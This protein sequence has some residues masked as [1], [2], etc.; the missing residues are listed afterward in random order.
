[1]YIYRRPQHLLL[2]LFPIFAVAIVLLLQTYPAMA[3]E[4]GLEEQAAPSDIVLSN[5]QVG[6]NQPAGTLVGTLSSVDADPGD[7][8]SY[9]VL[10]GATAYFAVD[11]DRLET[12]QALDFETEDR[13]Q[14]WI[15]STD[16]AGQSFYKSFTIVVTDANEAPTIEEGTSVAQTMSEDGSPTPFVLTLHGS[17]VDAGDSLSWSVISPAAHGTATAGG[18]GFSKVIGYAPNRNYHGSDSFEVQVTDSGGLTDTIRVHVTIE[19]VNDAP[20]ARGDSVTT[21]EERSLTISPLQND[22]DIDGDTISLVA[23]GEP[24]HGQVSQ[25]GNQITYTPEADFVGRDQINYGISDGTLTAFAT[26]NVYV[27]NVNDAPVIV[28]GTSASVTMSEDGAP[29][30]FALALSATDIDSSTVQWAI[31]SPPAHGTARATSTGPLT[32]AIDYT[33]ELHYHGTDTFR[34]QVSDGQAADVIWVDV[35]VEPVN[36]AP[37]GVD[38]TAETAEETAVIIDVLA[39]DSDVVEGS[40]LIV[41]DAGLPAHG[42]ATVNG[43]NEIVYTPQADFYGTDSFVY[44]LSDGEATSTA[45]VLVTVRNS[46]DAPVIGIVEEVQWELVGPPGFSPPVVKSFFYHLIW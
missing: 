27:T 6:E 5:D 44:T 41:Q 36:D 34:V 31:L 24:A 13:H 29:T 9:T 23:V 16:A 12:T 21:A 15:R 18:S 20:Q 33:P 19:P 14:L 43:D 11:G 22:G 38:D 8:H 4:H 45:T 35:T 30:P 37:L 32:G 28:E 26:I 1:M 7:T 46:N 25:S 2:A 17:D 39:N 42:F 3:V 40:P 10:G